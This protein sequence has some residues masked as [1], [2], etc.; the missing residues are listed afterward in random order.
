MKTLVGKSHGKCKFCAPGAMRL[1]WPGRQ[2][3]LACDYCR[4]TCLEQSDSK[5][6]SDWQPGKLKGDT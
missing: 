2:N 6:K 3:I 1:A 4:A 5:K